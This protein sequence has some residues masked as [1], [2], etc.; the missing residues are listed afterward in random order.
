M[1]S[2]VG[3]NIIVTGASSGIGKTLAIELAKNGANIVLA[4]R[5]ENKLNEV[6]EIITSLGGKCLVVPTDITDMASCQHLI[7]VT[8][9]NFGGIDILINNAGISMR[10]LFHETDL[11]V[12][13]KVMDTNFWGAVHC[14]KAAINELLK[15]N[16]MV[17][18]VSSITGLKG[19]P[20]R[21][22]Y[23]ASKF[24]LHGF[25]E[26]LRMEYSKT[27][28]HVLLACPGFTATNI[29][30]NALNAIGEPQGESPKEEDRLESP[31]NVAKEIIVAIKSK[32]SLLVQ[33]S[34]GKAIFWIN[35]FFPNW[36]ERKIYKEMAKEHGAPFPR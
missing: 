29:R 31:E 33:T 6:E 24:A 5:N 11:A 1:K 32:K 10:A 36:L 15:T 9:N 34:K 19:L 25:F 3:K 20:G 21:T 27:G 16:G 22:A 7:E 26:S 14:T 35:K 17:V 28:L 12:V 23:A 2:L 4:S 8:K 18:V 13:K 30:K